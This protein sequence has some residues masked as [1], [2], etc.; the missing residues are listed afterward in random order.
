MPQELLD[1]IARLAELTDDELSA[2]LVDIRAFYTETRT[3]E[4]A[5]DHVAD[6]QAAVDA[7][8]AVEAVQAERAEIAAQVEEALAGLD[9]EM[10]DPEPEP[11]PDEPEAP[12]EEEVAEV[13]PEP[14]PEPIVE[15]EPVAAAAP[16]VPAR[17]APVSAGAAHVPA[18]RAP[19]PRETQP[20]GRIVSV[21]GGTEGNPIQDGLAGIGRLI[22]DRASAFMGTNG[23][24]EKIAVAK[25]IAEYPPERTLGRDAVS[26]QAKIEAVGA[27]GPRPLVAAGGICIPAQPYYDSAVVADDARPVAASMQPFQARGGVTYIPPTDISD[28]TPSEWTIALDEAVTTSDA[29]W[30][31]VQTIVC[32]DEVTVRPHAAL[33]IGEF[34]NWNQATN[35]ERVTSEM[36]NAMAAHARLADTLLLRDIR[37]GSTRLNWAGNVGGPVGAARDTLVAVGQAAAGYRNRFRMPPEA[38]LNWL[39]PAWLRDA[40]QSDLVLQ[41]PGDDAIVTSYA[42]IVGYLAALNVRPYFYLD[43]PPTTGTAAGPSQ[44]FSTPSNNG[45]VPTY[46]G[47]AQWALFHDGAWLFG[48]QGDMTMGPVRDSSLNRRNAFQ[49]FVETFE[50]AAMVGVGSYWVTQIVSVAGG[51][52]TGEDLGS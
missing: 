23:N 44:Y 40:I 3:A 49:M 31:P 11:E 16:V 18:S 52:G 48:D 34:G 33:W 27:G 5:R 46:P 43:S 30:K 7:R 21:A 19:R 41:Q 25:V 13:T 14:G 37:T 6:L 45:A 26:N 24:G 42:E 15:P 47:Y 20:V 8:K 28:Y 12:V 29:T 39:A 51:F 35:P 32:E 17:R 4:D 10:A 2:L 9:A 1:R 38:T 36:A 22:A 50:L